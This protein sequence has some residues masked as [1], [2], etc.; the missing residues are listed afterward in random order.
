MDIDDFYTNNG[1]MMFID[2]MTTFLG[3]P[4]NKLKIVSVIQGSVIIDY[5][6]ILD[7]ETKNSE[8]F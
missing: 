4:S 3:I 8:T 5:E 7:E 1:E 6:V 2:K